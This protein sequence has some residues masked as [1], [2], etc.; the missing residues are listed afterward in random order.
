MGDEVAQLGL[1][2]HDQESHREDSPVAFSW[3][4]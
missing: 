1:I 3:S 2:T 4:G